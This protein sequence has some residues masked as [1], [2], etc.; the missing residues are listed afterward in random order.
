MMAEYSVLG[1]DGQDGKAC[2]KGLLFV[3]GKGSFK[4]EFSSSY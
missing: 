3:L 1:V 4:D 2:V